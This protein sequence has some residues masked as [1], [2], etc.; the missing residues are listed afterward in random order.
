MRVADACVGSTPAPAPLL[1]L[2]LQT[3]LCDH[4]VHSLPQLLVVQCLQGGD[5]SAPSKVVNKHVSWVKLLKVRV[6]LCRLLSPGSCCQQGL[7][8]HANDLQQQDCLDGSYAVGDDSLPPAFWPT[9]AASAAAAAA[10]LL[11][12][13]ICLF[14]LGV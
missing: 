6:R 12:R 13:S 4:V 5:A 3:H 11:L 9:A 7:C 8:Y 2:L 10:R 14:L 1:L